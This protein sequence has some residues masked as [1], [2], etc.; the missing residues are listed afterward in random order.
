MNLRLDWCS[1]E[2]AKYAVMNWHYSKTMPLPPLVKIGVWEDDKFIGVI[3][4]ARGNTPTLGNSYSLSQIE[5]CELVRVALC[6]HL[7]PVSKIVSIA[8]KMLKKHAPGLRLVVSFADP[9]HGHNGSIYQA[10][11]WIYTG[12]TGK[13]VQW[14]HN[15]HWKHNREMTSGAFGGPRKVKEYQKL[16]SRELPGKYRYLYPLDSAMRKQIEPLRKPY[17]KRGTGERDSAAG[18]NPQT[19]G[20]SPIVP[21][22]L[23]EQT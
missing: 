2:A 9:Y 12:E 17:P 15:G 23:E 6:I 7:S 11:N 1:Y 13:A 8:I 19:E 16:P 22:L 10:M 21:L 5:I 3:L 4:F 18:T 20:A 14:L